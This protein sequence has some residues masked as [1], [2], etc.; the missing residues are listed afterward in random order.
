MQNK[1][2]IRLLASIGKTCFIDHYWDFKN[3]TDKQELAQKIYQNNIN[4]KPDKNITRIYCAI[5]IF[6][7]HLEKEA[8]ELVLKSKNRQITAETKRQA[9]E[10]L[11]K[12][13]N[14]E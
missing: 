14:Q 6:N 10:I 2:L 12:E 11:T 4:R 9:Q 5:Q 8:L 3:C 7:N 1:K 13:N